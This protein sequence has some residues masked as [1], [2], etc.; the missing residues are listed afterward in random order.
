MSNETWRDTWENTRD[1]VSEE[2]M[3]YMWDAASR[4]YKA[5][6][7]YFWSPKFDPAVC[8]TQFGL[9]EKRIEIQLVKRQATTDQIV[10]RCR[11]QLS[12]SAQGT[13][14]R[15]LEPLPSPITDF[16]LEMRLREL[17]RELNILLFFVREQRWPPATT[18][19]DDSEACLD[20]GSII[21]LSTRIDMPELQIL[22]AQFTLAFG[23]QFVDLASSGDPL[24]VR[25][26]FLTLASF[27]VRPHSAYE[28]LLVTFT[29]LQ[30]QEPPADPVEFPPP[31]S[32][33]TSSSSSSGLAPSSTPPVL[34]PFAPLIAVPTSAPPDDGTPS[35]WMPA[36]HPPMSSNY[37]SYLPS[38]P[39]FDEAH[40]APDQPL[41][42]AISTAE[43]ADVKASISVLDQ[44]RQA[45]D[46]LLAR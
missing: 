37:V 23:K 25:P 41:Y 43:L 1:Y 12:S 18:L 4:S 7:G 21:F 3:P 11:V 9:A 40:P 44:A 33:S 5:V 32:S 35:A 30:V 6:S 31:S 28:Q 42:P 24:Y 38:A 34:P 15:L 29:D 13:S 14:I 45:E 27:T 10:D 8:K 16:V 46:G 20:Y 26:K 22:R 17:Y 19:A 2:I 39:E 36:E